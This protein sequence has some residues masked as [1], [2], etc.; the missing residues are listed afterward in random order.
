MA[1]VYT[2]HVA[3]KEMENKIWRDIDISSKSTLAQLSYAILVVFNTEYNHLFCLY[4]KGKRYELRFDPD[5]PKSIRPN[6][7]HLEKMKLEPG[8]ELTMIYDYGSEWEFRI[9]FQG[10]RPMEKGKGN[11]YPNVTAGAGIGIKENMFPQEYL[12]YIPKEDQTWKPETLVNALGQEYQRSY[13]NFDLEH[14]NYGLTWDVRW[15]KAAY[16]H[17]K[18]SRW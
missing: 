2:F 5:A 16:E 12:E 1:E 10:S 4:Y 11:H 3:V 6:R 14:I 8:D 7:V 9:T 15:V 17:T 13:K 18:D